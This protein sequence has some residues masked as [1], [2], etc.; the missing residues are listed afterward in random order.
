MC[1]GVYVC[2]PVCHGVCVCVLPSYVSHAVGKSIIPMESN[3]NKIFDFSKAE[4]PVTKCSNFY[5]DQISIE[6][7]TFQVSLV[8]F[9][10]FGIISKLSVELNG[11]MSS[12][13]TTQRSTTTK[14]GRA[15]VSRISG[16]IVLG[17]LSTALRE[18]KSANGFMCGGKLLLSP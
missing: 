8:L 11:M 4:Q 3:I 7:S 5:C 16:S 6:A 17:G 12:T 2:V 10:G 14:S 15:L 9:P 1:H 18:G 13:R